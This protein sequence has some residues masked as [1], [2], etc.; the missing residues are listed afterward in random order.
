MKLEKGRKSPHRGGITY[1]PRSSCSWS[2]FLHELTLR[3]FFPLAMWFFLGMP[4]LF[5]M[6]MSILMSGMK[7]SSHFMKRWPKKMLVF[8]SFECTSFHSKLKCL[9]SYSVLT[10]WRNKA[11]KSKMLGKLQTTKNLLGSKSLFFF[12]LIIEQK[13]LGVQK[14][15]IKTR[16]SLE[17][18]PITWWPYLPGCKS[19]RRPEKYSSNVRKTSSGNAGFAAGETMWHIG[20]PGEM[21]VTCPV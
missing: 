1:A 2:P 13:W 10:I 9:Q 18:R 7:L 11:V 16:R 19:N 14:D 8:F 12:P 15:K 4:I 3:G 20:D 17:V 5:F 6:I 21:N